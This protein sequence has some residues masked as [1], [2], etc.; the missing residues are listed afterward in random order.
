MKAT[1]ALRLLADVTAHQWGMVTSAQAR[2][3][4]VSRLDLS[5]LAEAGH[6]ERLAH[7]VYKDAGAPS[8][9]LDDL[10]AA[11]LGTDPSR[12]ADVRLRDREKGVVIAGP[13]AA[14]L[15]DIGDLWGHSF[16]FVTPMRRQSQ[17]GEIRYRRRCLEPRDVAIVEGLPALSVECTIADLFSAEADTSHI[18]DALRD[19]SSRHRLDVDRLRELLAPRA[20]RAGFPKGDG[21][22]LLDHLLTMASVDRETLSD[23]IAANQ[24]IGA[25]VFVKYLE[26]FSGITETEL[27]ALD[28][29]AKTLSPPPSRF[30]VT[31]ETMRLVENARKAMRHG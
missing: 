22:A 23:Q 2:T 24:E 1:A 29:A 8:H 17:R 12:T 15:H 6:L 21:A 13:S 16:D 7:G 28:H 5:R 25:R 26:R 9:Q 18:A 11:W 3:L 31:P 19:A 10:R 20:M 14:R 30:P 4:G 27:R